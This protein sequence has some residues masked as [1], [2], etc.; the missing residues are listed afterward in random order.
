MTCAENNDVI[1]A[2]ASD[3]ADNVFGIWILPGRPRCYRYL[4]DSQRSRLSVERLAVDRVPIS[5]QISRRFVG[6]ACLP[7]L[8]RR[9]CRGWVF[10]DIEVQDPAPIVTQ[11]QPHEQHPECRC[12]YGKEI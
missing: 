1:H 8:A 2:L 6:S 12:R 4:F 11:N 9:P 5:D 7:K 3:R 10:R